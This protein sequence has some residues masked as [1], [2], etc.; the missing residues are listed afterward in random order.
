MAD[1]LKEAGRPVVTDKTSSTESKIDHYTCPFCTFQAPK[2]R[3]VRAHITTE[4]QGQHKERNGYLDQIHVQARDADGNLLDDVQSTVETSDRPDGEAITKLVPD[5]LTDKQEAILRVHL[6]NPSASADAVRSRI[7]ERYDL[8]VSKPYIT[9]CRNRYFKMPENAVPDSEASPSYG[10]LTDKQQAVVDELAKTADPFDHETWDIKVSELQDRAGVSYGTYKTVLDKYESVVR[11]QWA[12]TQN[13][14]K[15]VPGPTETERD[16][17]DSDADESGG[18]SADES[19]DAPTSVDVSVERL[20]TY[21]R[22]MDAVKQEAMGQKAA[23]P[24]DSPM[25]THAA[26]KLEVVEKAEKF[27]KQL[28]RDAESDVLRGDD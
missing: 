28:A 22:Q 3:L 18:E 21:A 10:D 16:A 6:V 7:K 15:S 24:E 9:N 5:G 1:K 8:D 20:R 27:L 19:G 12:K 2:E 26:G 17:S 25:E 4:T 14:P 23:A 11:H 13:K